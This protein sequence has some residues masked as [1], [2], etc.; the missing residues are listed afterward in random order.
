MDKPKEISMPNEM[1]IQREGE[2]H[3]IFNRSFYDP[4]CV[5]LSHLLVDNMFGGHLLSLDGQLLVVDISF[6]EFL[7][8]KLKIKGRLAGDKVARR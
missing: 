3:R 5:P 7:S 1:A 2:A 6:Q 4:L 8:K